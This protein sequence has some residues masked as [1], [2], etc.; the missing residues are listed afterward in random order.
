MFWHHMKNLFHLLLLFNLVFTC[1]C[2]SPNS[3]VWS[4]TSFSIEFFTLFIFLKVISF[5]LES[6]LLSLNNLYICI[7]IFIYGKIR[8]FFSQK[9]FLVYIQIKF[10]CLRCKYS[11][12]VPF[13]RSICTKINI[14]FISTWF[15]TEASLKRLFLQ[16]LLLKNREVFWFK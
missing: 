7:Y 16:L 12:F 4:S 15:S 11:T 3:I 5:H 9:K 13:S 10:L 8:I 1:S 14:I 6:I 2:R